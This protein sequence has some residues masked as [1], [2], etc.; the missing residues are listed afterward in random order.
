[1][2]KEQNRAKKLKWWMRV[3]G[4][5]YLLLGI[6]N[7]PPLMAARMGV[8]YPFLELGLEHLAVRA[9]IDLWFVFGAESAVLGLMLLLASAAPLRNKILVQMVLLLELVRILLDLFWIGRGYYDV[10]PY[11]IWIVFHT[12]IILSGWRFLRQAQTASARDAAG[13]LLQAG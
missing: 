3:I 10:A 7:A 1:M 9:I 2:K 11:I 4:A 6:I 12:A 13:S 8:Q 5:F